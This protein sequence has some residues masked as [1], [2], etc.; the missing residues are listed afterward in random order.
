MV[1]LGLQPPGMTGARTSGGLAVANGGTS[2]GGFFLNSSLGGTRAMRW[3]PADGMMDLGT[4]NGPGNGFSRVADM[5]GDGS[6]L[7]GTAAR[8]SGFDGYIWTEET[9]MVSIGGFEA[10]AVTDDAQ[11]IAGLGDGSPFR[12]TRWDAERGHVEIG[13]L[14][15]GDLGSIPQDIADDGRTIVGSARTL[16]S[17]LGGDGEVEQAFRWTEE[18]GMQGLG[19]LPGGSTYSEAIAVSADGSMVF[20]SSID[21]TGANAA[22]IWTELDGMR[23][24]QDVLL[25]DFDIAVPDGWRLLSVESASADGTVLAGRGDERARCA[26][27]VGGGACRDGGRWVCSGLVRSS[28]GVGGGGD[29][30]RGEHGVRCARPVTGSVMPPCARACA[31]ARVRRTPGRDVSSRDRRSRSRRRRTRAQAHAAA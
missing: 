27:S 5:N 12:A 24:L 31:C 23:N 16:P 20:G 17:I 8:S 3:T 19:W 29:G 26:R 6:V 10:Y 21:G 25:D 30:G 18:G 28:R 14:P 13:Q 9:G 15:G 22:F 7:V 11:Y 2:V 4:L 1:P